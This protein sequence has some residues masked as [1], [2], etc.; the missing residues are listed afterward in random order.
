LV[1]PGSLVGCEY[2]ALAGDLRVKSLP[3]WEG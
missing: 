2:G 1:S 3:D